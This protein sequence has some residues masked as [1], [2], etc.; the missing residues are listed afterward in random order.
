MIAELRS[1]AL[2]TRD[3]WEFDR[4][5]TVSDPRGVPAEM[6]APWVECKKHANEMYWGDRDRDG[7]P[8]AKETMFRGAV[9]IGCVIMQ[10]PG[11][12]GQLFLRTGGAW[13]IDDKEP[14]VARALAQQLRATADALEKEAGS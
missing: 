10:K 1:I 11:V 2:P 6:A 3:F 14:E 8:A 4:M 5:V 9:V 12:A 13:T 7:P